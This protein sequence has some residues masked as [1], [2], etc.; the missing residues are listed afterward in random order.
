M[1]ILLSHILWEI[2]YLHGGNNISVWTEVCLLGLVLFIGAQVEGWFIIFQ[3]CCLKS[4]T[5]WWSWLRNTVWKSPDLRKNVIFIFLQTNILFPLPLSVSI[6]IAYT[7]KLLSACNILHHFS[8]ATGQL[9]TFSTGEYTM[10][11]F[12]DSIG[13]TAYS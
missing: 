13:F 9:S 7:D 5:G 11:F 1:L 8:V 4:E 12:K 3:S 2:I 6:W 10:V